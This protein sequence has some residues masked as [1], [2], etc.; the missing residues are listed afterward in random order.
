MKALAPW[1]SFK[2]KQSLR[3]QKGYSCLHS[4]AI[5]T[6]GPM[7]SQRR[8]DEDYGIVAIDVESAAKALFLFSN[9]PVTPQSSSPAEAFLTRPVRT[10]LDLLVLKKPDSV[11]PV[12]K[13]FIHNEQFNHQRKAHKKINC[14]L[15]SIYRISTSMP[16]RAIER[17]GSVHYVV[18][19]EHNATEDRACELKALALPW[20]ILLNEVQL[21]TITIQVDPEK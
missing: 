19:L 17:K 20:E 21:Q 10:T 14:T 12:A 6:L 9:L 15:S 2:F 5:T 16:S 8:S 3:F 13:K 4:E 11:A 18:S 1:R 7:S